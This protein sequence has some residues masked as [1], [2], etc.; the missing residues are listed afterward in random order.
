MKWNNT[1]NVQN[2]TRSTYVK[3][4]IKKT[5]SAKV[6]WQGKSSQVRRSRTK[7]G[8]LKTQSL[9]KEDGEYVK[10]KYGIR[11]FNNFQYH[12]IG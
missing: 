10:S 2:P 7:K 4:V 1:S 3:E 6:C 5:K 11:A 12:M 9:F 8:F